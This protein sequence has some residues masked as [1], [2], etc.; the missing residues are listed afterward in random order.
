[1]KRK[2]L[3]WRPNELEVPFSGAVLWLRGTPRIA[4][5]SSTLRNLRAK[6]KYNPTQLRIISTGKAM[7][8]VATHGGAHWWSMTRE[9]FDD[10]FRPYRDTAP[11][12]RK[13]AKCVVNSTCAVVM[14]ASLPTYVT[15]FISETSCDNVRLVLRSQEVTRRKYC[16]IGSQS[17]A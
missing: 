11:D 16:S 8:I 3:V 12:K 1:V 15:T 13:E 4:N 14:H 10:I 2:P 7:E 5:I 6:R 9:Q 17:L